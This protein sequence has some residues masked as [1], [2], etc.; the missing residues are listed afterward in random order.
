MRGL[1]KISQRL[2][3]K[4]EVMFP[5]EHR[6]SGMSRRALP[7]GRATAPSMRGPD[8]LVG[9]A[10]RGRPALSSI[11]ISYLGLKHPLLP[12]TI[13]TKHKPQ[14]HHNYVR[15]NYRLRKTNVHEMP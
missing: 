8:Q 9:A 5:V 3:T 7:N 15:H 12:S 1:R 2:D 6:R 14:G 10:L 11:S 4:A 13:G